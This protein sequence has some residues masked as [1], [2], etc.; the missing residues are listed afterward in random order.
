MLWG[1]SGGN[2]YLKQSRGSNYN[3]ELPLLKRLKLKI[4]NISAGD[5]SIEDSDRAVIDE[6]VRSNRLVLDGLHM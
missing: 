4:V 1:K 3:I 5:I 2:L 6:F